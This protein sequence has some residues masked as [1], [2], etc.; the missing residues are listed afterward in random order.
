MTIRYDSNLCGIFTSCVALCMSLKEIGS[1][2]RSFPGPKSRSLSAPKHKD[3]GKENRLDQERLDSICFVCFVCL[4]AFS[5][6]ALAT[7]GG[8]QARGPNGAAAASHSHSHS[9][10]RSEPRLQPI[11]Q[12][13]ATPDP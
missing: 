4:F 2:L 13:T 6:A 11:P 12:V 5:G 9:N 8:S 1:T 3:W 10:A 7:Y